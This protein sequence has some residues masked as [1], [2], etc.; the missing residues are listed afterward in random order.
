MYR[1][2]LCTTVGKEL[3]FINCPAQAK[4]LAIEVYRWIGAAMKPS[5]EKSL[6]PVQVR[7][8]YV[9]NRP[10]PTPELLLHK[11]FQIEGWNISIERSLTFV[12]QV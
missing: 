6:K 4:A 5:L 2:W 9:C 12:L 11:I 1:G 3:N 10:R 8:H 7:C